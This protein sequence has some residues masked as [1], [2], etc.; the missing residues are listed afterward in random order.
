[1]LFH[2][3]VVSFVA[4]ITLATS[5]TASPTPPLTGT[6]NPSQG[7]TEAP[8]CSPGS[9]PTSCGSL[10]HFFTLSD[11]DQAALKALDPNLD[12]TLPVGEQCSAAGAQGWYCVPQLPY[13]MAVND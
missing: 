7:S 12:R 5:V 9:N 2:K 10:T 8:S 4:A 13:S 11:G 1:M 6:G 3:S